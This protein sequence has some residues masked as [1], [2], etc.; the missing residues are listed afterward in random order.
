MKTIIAFLTT[1]LL[2]AGATTAIAAEQDSDEAPGYAI[3]LQAAQGFG[4]AQDAR[5]FRG[6]YA[7]ARLPAKV[8]Y[9]LE[10]R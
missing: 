6:A 2:V 9:Q 3:S 8:D 10:G 1:T 4:P 5:S 7:S